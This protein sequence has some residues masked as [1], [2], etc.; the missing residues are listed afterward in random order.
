MKCRCR[1]G[2][3]LRWLDS[4]VR[5]FSRGCGACCSPGCRGCSGSLPPG[6]EVALTELAVGQSGRVVSVASGDQDLINRFADYGLVRG[7]VVTV[8]EQALFGGPM[9]LFVQGSMVVLRRSEAALIRVCSVSST[10]HE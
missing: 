9:L 10:C 4:L 8:H 6:R 3:W 7:I 5:R 2:R 1:R